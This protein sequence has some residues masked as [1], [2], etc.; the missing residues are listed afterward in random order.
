MHLGLFRYFL[1]YKLIFSVAVFCS[2]IVG[3]AEYAN[4]Y[5]VKNV[6]DKVFI[7]RDN[8]LL[9]EIVGLIILIGL[10]KAVSRF[11]QGTIMQYI[12][13]RYIQQVR[14]TL[15]S[16]IIY[17]PIS[18][19]TTQHSGNVLSRVTNDV[20]LLENSLQVVISIFRS[21]FVII[22]M[23]SY[24]FIQDWY[25]AFL[26]TI[27][28]PIFIQPIMWISKKI[29]RYSKSS[30]ERLGILT[31][32]ISEMFS[33]IRVVKLF[34]AETTTTSSFQTLNENVSKELISRSR[35]MVL[36][37]PMVEF[38]GIIGLAIVIYVGGSHVL[39]GTLTQGQFFTFIMALASIF[40]PLRIISSGNSNLQAALAALERINHIIDIDDEHK[41]N[42]NAIYDK[43]D[44]TGKSLSFRN[45]WFKYTKDGRYVLKNIHFTVP[46]G[47]KYAVIGASGG[48]K[49][50][51]FSLITRFYDVTL[52]GIFLGDTPITKY[53]IHAYRDNFGVVTQ[54][55]FLFSGSI[56]DNIVYNNEYDE[57]RLWQAIRAANLLDVV[58]AL[59]DG[60]D[61]L[62]GERGVML[63]GGQR[64]RVTIARAVYK[65]PPFLL[66]DEATSALDSESEKLVQNALEN[67]MIGR[68][69]IVV[70]H[71][72]STILNSDAIVVIEDGEVV[73]IGSHAE[74]IERS[75]VYARIY[76]LQ[77][78]G[79]EL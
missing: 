20:S 36:N 56:K 55:T 4:L 38:V 53:N 25:L 19:F 18:F 45:V 31:Q 33:G 6:I 16:K 66:L 70:A 15:F 73:D 14:D 75:D 28:Y 40:A 77:E 57:D 11:F 29:R 17:L 44:F 46:A 7:E 12:G 1:R 54:D 34:N 8:A 51:I 68:T 3:L 79:V 71:R 78:L 42:A 63:S 49:S 52:G 27:C 2:I 32:Y 74:L 41:L 58:E 10:V 24:L 13:I 37:E 50:T 69:S 76:K 26:S 59:P 62:V 43:C 61:T 60:V 35:I 9:Y 30:Q 47:K 21:F 48:G 67:L 72:L 65:N 39:D 22:L 5:I 23:V 64:Q